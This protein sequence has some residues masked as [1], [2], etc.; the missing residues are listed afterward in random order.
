MSKTNIFIPALE[1]LQEEPWSV[2]FER[3]KTFV[4]VRNKSFESFKAANPNLIISGAGGLAAVSTWVW[5]VVGLVLIGAVC[6]VYVFAESGWM[7]NFSYQENNSVAGV[8]EKIESQNEVDALNSNLNQKVDQKIPVD[9]NSNS[10][11]AT[12]QSSLSDIQVTDTL[13][14]ANSVAIVDR[15]NPKVTT[16]YVSKPAKSVVSKPIV[17]QNPV[18]AIQTPVTPPAS[19]NQTPDPVTIPDSNTPTGG[20]PAGNNQGNDNNGNDG[21]GGGEVVDPGNGSG[22]PGDSG[23][24]QGGSDPNQNPGDNGG[25]DNT[26]PGNSNDGDGN[27]PNDPNDSGN[28]GSDPGNN[29]SGGQTGNDGG[30]GNDNNSGNPTNGGNGNNAT[31]LLVAID[32]ETDYPIS[33][34]CIDGKFKRETESGSGLYILTTGKHYVSY[35]D[36]Y[37]GKVKSHQAGNNSK[38]DSECDSFDDVKKPVNIK[39]YTE[40]PNDVTVIQLSKK[41]N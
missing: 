31:G 37:I 21:V 18:V 6:A 5:I 28:G 36:V 32:R 39:P 41:I 34:L 30:S 16:V 38:Y 15:P 14:T 35:P 2:I 9:V 12:T 19:S 33:T 29:N 7:P 26:D 1:G 3:D 24:G 17:N 23:N 13:N 25:Q 22:K 40:K 8:S 11:T 27:Q 20:T 4:S 10:E